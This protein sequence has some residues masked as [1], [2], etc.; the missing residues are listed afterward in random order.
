LGGDDELW[1]EWLARHGPALVLYARQWLV[2]VA[3]AEDAVQD[4]FVRFWRAKSRARRRVAYLYACVRSAAIDLGRSD[5]SRRR[6]EAVE[7]PASASL[8]EPAHAELAVQVE[9]ALARLGAEQRQVVV[10]KIWGG[11]TFAQIAEALAINSNTAAS[12]YRYALA[13]L[14]TTLSR[15]CEIE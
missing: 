9:A 14:E 2:N 1:R 11:L 5:R 3:D 7:A 15:S 6:R 10:M 13:Q 8:F 4:G 12:R